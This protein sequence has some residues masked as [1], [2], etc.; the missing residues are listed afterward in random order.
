M[1][2]RRACATVAGINDQ[3]T[4]RPVSSKT[5]RRRLSEAPSALDAA[6][7][8]APEIALVAGVGVDAEEPPGLDDDGLDREARAGHRAFGR[9]RVAWPILRPGRASALP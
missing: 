7:G 3:P 6:A 1:I 2:P 5:S 8:H 4:A 9:I